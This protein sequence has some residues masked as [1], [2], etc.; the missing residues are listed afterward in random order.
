MDRYFLSL[1]FIEEKKFPKKEDLN[2]KA[3]PKGAILH[4]LDVKLNFSSL[5]QPGPVKNRD[6][7]GTGN[8]KITACS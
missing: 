8:S 6:P 4:E 5:M 1:L 3:I 7:A 2:V